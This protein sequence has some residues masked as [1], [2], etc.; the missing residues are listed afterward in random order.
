M[1]NLAKKNPTLDGSSLLCRSSTAVRCWT[2]SS[3]V[4]SY[5]IAS[6]LISSA[7]TILKMSAP[8][9]DAGI[10]MARRPLDY[11]DTHILSM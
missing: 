7:T 3:A 1:K 4:L 6:R 5:Q 9:K 10:E 8:S 11:R 2:S